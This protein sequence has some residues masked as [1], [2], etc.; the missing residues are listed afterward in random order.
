MIRQFLT[1]KKLAEWRYVGFVQLMIFLMDI[2][3]IFMGAVVILLSCGLVCFRMVRD[4]REKR[5]RCDYTYQN[6][7]GIFF[8]G[9]KLRSIVAS[10]FFKHMS[11]LLCIP[12]ILVTL[13][14]WRSVILLRK[15]HAHNYFEWK[16]RKQSIIQFLQLFIDLPCVFAGV[17]VLLSWRVPFYIQN[18]KKM[19]GA[20]RR[21]SAWRFIAFKHL[22]LLFVDLFCFIL[23]LITFLTWRAPFLIYD[24]RHDCDSQWDARRIVVEQFLLIFV[25]VP[26]ILCFVF[27]SITL[28]RLPRFVKNFKSDQWQFRKNC[29]YQAGMLFIDFGCFL[30][31]TIVVM[32]LWRLYPLVKDVQ[33]YK[34]RARIPD[35]ETAD[36]RTTPREF[37]SN[38]I[39]RKSSWKIRKAI[40]KHFAFLFVDLPAIVVMIFILVTIFRIPSVFSKLLQSG[41]FYAEFAMIVFVEAGKLLVDIVFVFFFVFLV[42]L[43]PIASWVRLLED[44][45]HARYRQ[46]CFYLEWIPDMIRD[47]RSKLPVALEEEFSSCLK[48]RVSAIETR[49]RMSLL[50]REYLKQWEWL[51][52]KVQKNYLDP[53]LL[54]LLTTSI[55]YEKRRPYKMSRLYSCE[56]AYLLK[57]VPSAHNETLKLHQ[58]EMTE[59]EKCVSSTY[60][61]LQKFSPLKVP[62]WSD[63]CGLLTRSRQETQKVL[64]RLPGGNIFLFLVVIVNLLLIYRGPK[65][66]LDLWRRWYDRRSIIFRSCKEYLLDA[67]TFL[68]ILIVVL[69]IYRA[70]AILLDI[71]IDI[72]QKQSWKAVRATAKRYPLEIVED[73]E[74]LVSM[75]FRWRTIRFL[76]TATLFGILIPADL[77]LTVMKF[78]VSKGAAYLIAGALFVIFMAFP[79]VFSLHFGEELLDDGYSKKI[80]YIIVGYCFS[81]VVLLLL[82]IVILLKHRG[83]KFSVAPKPFDYVRLNWANTHVIVFEIVELL[84]LLALVFSIDGIPMAGSGFL[85]TCANYLLFNFATFEVKLSLTI[86]GFM[87]WFATCGAPIIFEHILEEFPEGTCARKDGWRLLMVLLYNTLFV[88][89]VEGL[90]GLVACDYVDVCIHNA[91]MQT[92]NSSCYMSSLVDDTI[93]R[94]WVGKHRVIALFGLWGLFWYSTT[95]IIYG[96]QYGE[97]DSPNVDIEFS[98]VYN[99]LINFLK[100]VMVGAVVLIPE[101]FYIV[102]TCLLVLSLIAILSTAFF[103]KLIGYPSCNSIV[104]NY[105]RILSFVIFASAVVAAFVAKHVNDNDSYTPLIVFFVG[106]GGA[107]LIA[108]IASLRGRRET[109]TEKERKQFREML[110]ALE[111]RLSRERA[112]GHSW[113]GEKRKWRRLVR[114]VYE[115]QKFDRNLKPETWEKIALPEEINVDYVSPPACPPPPPV[116]PYGTS[117]DPVS[118]S[119]SETL[120]TSH[121]PPTSARTVD[122]PST[123]LSLSVH[124]AP[125]KQ[126]NSSETARID[127]CELDTIVTGGGQES[128]TTDEFG[129]TSYDVD[130]AI[131]DVQKMTIDPCAMTS[132]PHETKFN[133]DSP[134]LDHDME[135]YDADSFLKKEV[136]EV[137][138]FLDSKTRNE[139]TTMTNLQ[140]NGKS[141][142]LFLEG[143]INFRAFSFAFVSQ[144]PLWRQAVSGSNWTGLL[145]CL[146]VLEKALTG[147]YDRPTELD[148]SLGDNRVPTCVLPPD[149]DQALPPTFVPES[150]DPESIKL[151]SDNERERI[152]DDVQR[153]YA[154]EPT[155]FAVFDKVL[156]TIPVIRSWKLDEESNSFELILRRPCQATVVDIG[157]KGIKLAKGALIA[158]PKNIKGTMKNERLLFNKSF[159]PTGKKGPISIKV[160]EIHISRFSDKVYL[161][162]NGKKINAEKALDSLKSIK[163]R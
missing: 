135:T 72:F 49:I 114:H 67:L 71:A 82:L 126:P 17:I 80:T 35:T 158:L 93:T 124:Q 129:A 101:D 59:Y 91:T 38:V 4:F 138:R 141:L 76:F 150:R 45:E 26:C 69:L 13:F 85:N 51:R 122:K 97:V 107:L 79:F 148:V 47:T 134:T 62:L 115:A 9:F 24:L 161:H 7:N 25:D 34:K 112:L 86:V 78:A 137:Q 52:S 77:L 108:F 145:H 96:M 125:V 106:S 133:T 8:G 33:K 146:Q 88:S 58:Q 53:E 113:Q 155:W 157:P 15:L 18:V 92:S 32:T 2:P 131:S 74:R 95:S 56:L 142:L 160:S 61:E 19:R 136:Y 121:L 94:C 55:W 23:F 10:Y 5:V 102:M 64:I 147:N 6:S 40:C 89:M 50:C 39:S 111:K 132:E 37:E 87:V 66:L 104:V 31:F 116:G 151:Q 153:V 29:V 3:F 22:L 109:P 119:M 12:L 70:P 149:P 1:M 128:V 156:P 159:E 57:P 154:D 20:G 99:T 41:D 100:A 130:A 120:A 65:L 81:I 54:H 152:L 30:L 127:E 75:V 14:S 43:R 60:E 46:V 143:F 163:W 84:Q 105:F 16:W 73:L 44:K 103:K 36:T 123:P 11:G 140:C 117:C 21:W 27:V 42:I 83:S 144:I 139:T 28:W 110:L 90:C 162:S 118:T 68:R 48:T 63:K 98:P